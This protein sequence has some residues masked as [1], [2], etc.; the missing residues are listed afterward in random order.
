MATTEADLFIAAGYRRTWEI[1]RGGCEI[2]PSFEL[3]THELKE[4]R[5]ARGPQV[6]PEEVALNITE[7][8][9]RTRLFPEY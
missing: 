4:A 8:Y 6:R 5:K 3:F 7:R 9:H 2:P 1:L